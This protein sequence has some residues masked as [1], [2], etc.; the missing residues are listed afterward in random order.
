M[1][2]MKKKS[3]PV[4]FTFNP[5]IKQIYIKN[6]RSIEAAAIDC[7]DITSFVGQNDAGKSNILR[8]L[9]LFFNGHT[10]HAI[11][12]EFDRDFNIFAPVGKNKAKEVIIELTIELPWSY[13]REGYSDN[14]VW[15]KVWRSN[16]LHDNG[17]YCHYEDKQPF[18]SRSRVPL[19]LE[20]IVYNY[21]PAI[22]D[23]RYF[24][25]L[26][27]QV[28]DVLSTVA[29]QTLHQSASTFENQIQEH[30][31]ELLT[32][33]SDVFH[34]DSAMRLPG[35]LREVFENLEFNANGIPLSRRGDGIKI[36]HIPMILRFIAEKRNSIHKQGAS[37]HIWGFEEPENNVEM[38]ACFGMSQQFIDAAAE[39][40]QIFIT[41]HSPVFYGMGD[42][43]DEE[44]PVVVY[45][46]KK[47][48]DFS[49]ITLL[50]R[51]TTDDEMGLMPLVAPYVASER[52]IWEKRLADAHR[53]QE[54]TQQMLRKLQHETN[55]S[56]PH[57]FVEGKS[58]KKIIEK[59]IAIFFTND[60]TIQVMCGT[61]AEYGGAQAAANRAVA[62]QLN[63][64][65]RNEP[66]SAALLLDKDDAGDKA[67]NDF[68][69]R[70]KDKQRHFVK[71]FQWK[72]NKKPPLLSA[73]FRMPIDLENLYPD[74]VWIKGEQEGWLAPIEN[75]SVR[76][77]KSKQDAILN[78]AL[79]GNSL[80]PLD[81]L[82]ENDLRRATKTFTDEGKIKAAQWIEKLPKNEA[83]DVLKE[84][85]SIL[86][87]ILKH[88]LPNNA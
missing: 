12:F 29:A 74:S 65:T 32:S 71:A 39:D 35:N 43:N 17:G 3:T 58:D 19:L 81:G 60:I 25:D 67:K 52:N 66:V 87:E 63:Q 78:A 30:L 31:K 14:I 68:N 83:C 1:A 64:E 80:N 55:T 2:W 70:V 33:V 54:Q 49:S 77:K 57:L 15:R 11:P 18:P 45:N 24:A 88:L 7:Q 62:W 72:W 23:K 85:E 34:T 36:R 37:H 10:D 6:F 41:T 16:G 51:A 5:M 75:P 44:N 40:F 38:A 9:N 46:V 27:G 28:Y 42:T 20:R 21:V 53:S 61:G 76:I 22:K 56:I 79:S 13:R 73:G 47:Q 84:L 82:D 8:A 50:D 59:A 4:P 26:Q 69:D 48:G 86:E